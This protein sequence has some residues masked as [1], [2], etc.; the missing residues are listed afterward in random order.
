MRRI[1]IAA[2]SEHPFIDT[3]SVGPRPRGSQVKKYGG[4][5]FWDLSVRAAEVIAS[6]NALSQ[7]Q[8]LGLAR[9]NG[10]RLF[11]ASRAILSLPLQVGTAVLRRRGLSSILSP[12]KNWRAYMTFARE[13]VTP[14]AFGATE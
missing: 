14:L 10:V 9:Y 4:Y 7:P 5:G 11:S 6:R 3:P 2:H 12:Q 1:S 8:L 13:D